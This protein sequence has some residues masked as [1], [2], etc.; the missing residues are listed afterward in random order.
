MSTRFL[1]WEAGDYLSP[2]PYLRYC[3]QYLIFMTSGHRTA[4][5]KT[6][7]LPMGDPIVGVRGQRRRGEEKGRALTFHGTFLGL[8]VRVCAF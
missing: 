4:W 8:F 1:K 2:F 3:I 6:L 7:Q 5:T